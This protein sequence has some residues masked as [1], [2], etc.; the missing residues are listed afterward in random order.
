MVM[1]PTFAPPICLRISPGSTRE[2]KYCLS[3]A[4]VD[5]LILQV[6]LAPAWFY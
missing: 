3:L 1:S 4:V 2:H 6:I 5:R